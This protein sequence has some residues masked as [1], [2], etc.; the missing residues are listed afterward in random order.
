MATQSPYVRL[1]QM[2]LAELRVVWHSLD[3]EEALQNWHTPFDAEHGISWDD[4]A[5]NVKSRMDYLARNEGSKTTYEVIQEMTLPE[6][7]GASKLIDC[8]TCPVDSMFNVGGGITWADLAQ[9][10]YRQTEILEKTAVKIIIEYDTEGASPSKD[11]GWM[12]V[13]F[14]SGCENWRNREDYVVWDK[15]YCLRIPANV[16]IRRKLACGTAFFLESRT[17]SE[18]TWFIQEGKYVPQSEFAGILVWIDKAKD[19]GKDYEDRKK[20][21]EVFLEE[22]NDWAHG[23]CYQYWLINADG[24][25]LDSGSGFIGDAH[26]LASMKENHPEIFG[27]N[28]KVISSI[29]VHGDA[30]HVLD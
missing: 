24:D 27:E 1:D 12:F 17:H 13:G 9:A 25:D 21:A 16:G 7:R 19:C 28:G 22:Y 14:N 2:T 15:D 10:L 8:S 26:F 20:S 18:T 3:S 23:N 11:E 30:I 4:W 29:N 5:E 6:L